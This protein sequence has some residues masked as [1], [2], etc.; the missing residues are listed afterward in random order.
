[1]SHSPAGVGSI[2]SGAPQALERP[3]SP[4]GGLEQAAREFEAA[5]IRQI[6]E[7]ARLGGEAGATHGSMVVDALAG[8][9]TEGGGLG[10]ADLIARSLDASERA[11]SEGPP[12][13]DGAHIPR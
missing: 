10:L 8:A 2:G 4:A 9:I 6:L 1:M 7:T 11:A 12:L 3:S 5:L 13:V